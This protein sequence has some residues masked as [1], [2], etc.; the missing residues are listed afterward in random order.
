MSNVKDRIVKTQNIKLEI[1]DIDVKRV[2]A[3]IDGKLSD[4]WV[5]L[6]EVDAINDKLYDLMVGKLQ[7]HYGVLSIQ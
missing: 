5:S 6:E 1:T 4:E 2:Q 7:T 3:V